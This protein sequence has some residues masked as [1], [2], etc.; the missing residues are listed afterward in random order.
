M[1]HGCETDRPRGSD[2]DPAWLDGVGTLGLTAGAS[3]P[4]ELVREVVDRLS[5][6][7]KVEEHTLVTAEEKMVFK[8]PRQLMD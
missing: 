2:I 3:A 7:R 6:W 4:E 8:L 5:Q 1:R